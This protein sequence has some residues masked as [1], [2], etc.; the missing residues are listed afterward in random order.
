ML[1]TTNW[2]SFGVQVAGMSV[3][4]ADWCRMACTHTPSTYLHV[5]APPSVAR[6]TFYVRD[7]VNV[8]GDMACV[9]QLHPND[10]IHYAV[11]YRDGV[12][13]Q[14]WV[15]AAEMTLIARDD[16]WCVE[17]DICGSEP[18][19]TCAGPYEPCY[20]DPSCSDPSSPS[21]AGG[22]GCDAGGTWN[23]RFCGFNHYNPCP[24]GRHSGHHSD[25]DFA[26]SFDADFGQ[27]PDAGATYEPDDGS[28]GTQHCGQPECTDEV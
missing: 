3:T 5:G 15:D 27:N 22:L 1:D 24:D 19:P 28:T 20:N 9:V 17:A 26:S 11:D 18:K 8:D 12:T 13:A 25:A 7:R 14:E 23:C 21:Y 2:D 6:P 4:P 16:S 10:G